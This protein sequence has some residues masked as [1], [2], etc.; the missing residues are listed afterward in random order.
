[1]YKS[2][3]KFMMASALVGALAVCGVSAQAAG[4]LSADMRTDRAAYILVGNQ[5]EARQEGAKAFISDMANDAI[6]FISDESLD[7]AAK[8]KKFATLLKRNFDLSKIGRFALGQYWG[9]ATDQERKAYFGLFEDMIVETYSARFSEYSGQ[10][11]EVRSARPEGK[12]DILVS[13]IIVGNGG[14]SIDVDWRVR[15][16]SGGYRVI[17]VVVEGVSMAL[18]Q[19][20]EF[21]SVIQ[22]GGGKVATLITHLEK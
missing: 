22:R 14:P 1:M 8:T 15:Y 18:T 11:I 4:F 19:R 9:S 20:S 5:D 16:A 13:S 3:S 12:K 10:D 6:G 21:A 17:D 7:D 2:L